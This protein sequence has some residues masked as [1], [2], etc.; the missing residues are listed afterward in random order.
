MFR[1]VGYIVG[2]SHP[3]ILVCQLDTPPLP[4]L[5]I[6]KIT[7]IN[8]PY[9]IWLPVHRAECENTQGLR[10]RVF[11][12]QHTVLLLRERLRSHNEESCKKREAKGHKALGKPVYHADQ[13]FPVISRPAPKA[14]CAADL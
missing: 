4:D 13:P 7:A 9:L 14:C 1:G 10:C 3:F 2:A 11:H 5:N 12:A 6:N 8:L